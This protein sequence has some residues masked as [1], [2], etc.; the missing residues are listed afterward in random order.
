[1][2]ENLSTIACGG[3]TVVPVP[4]CEHTFFFRLT[5]IYTSVGAALMD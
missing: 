4:T 5:F 2:E 3:E 1:M